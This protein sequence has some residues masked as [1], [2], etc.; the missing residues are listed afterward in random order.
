M[1]SF[2]VDNGL[3]TMQSSRYFLLKVQVSFASSPQGLIT[4]PN[5]TEDPDRSF[6][7]LLLSIFKVDFYKITSVVD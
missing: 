5:Q 3:R 4:L 1:S 7:N 6:K 2:N